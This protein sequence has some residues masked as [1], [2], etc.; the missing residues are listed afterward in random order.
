MRLPLSIAAM[1]ILA[2]ALAAQVL[3]YRLLD[4][5]LPPTAGY[6]DGAAD[7]D[8]DG[9]VD[10]LT[11]AG[12]LVGDGHANFAAAAGAP[13]AS[14]RRNTRVADLNGDGL[15]DVLSV[16]VSGVPR[17]DVNGGGLVFAQLPGAIPTLP[18]AGPLGL[19][20]VFWRFTTGDVD[21]DGD[22]DAVAQVKTFAI[23]NYQNGSPLVLLNNGSATFTVAP[24]TAFPATTVV[25]HQEDLAD[26]DG[27]GDLD[28]LLTGTPVAA[29]GYSR[30]FVLTNSGAGTFSPPVQVFSGSSQL[31]PGVG[32]FNGDGFADV[33]FSSSTGVAFATVMFGSAAGLGPGVN[34]AFP[35][36]AQRVIAIDLNGDGSDEVL[37]GTGWQG[38]AAVFSISAAG[39]VGAPTQTLQGIQLAP[40]TPGWDVLTDF[41]QDGDRDL[42]AIPMTTPGASM[43]GTTPA[44]L[45]NDGAGALVLLGG[46]LRNY[47]ISGLAQ[48]GD[49]DADGDL[50][51]LGWGAPGTVPTIETSLNDGDGFFTSGPL[52]PISAPAGTWNYLLFHA[53]DRDGDGDVD[54][55]AARNM[56][57]VNGTPG[58]DLVLDDVGGV[59][60]VAFTLA[61]TGPVTAI[62]DLDVDGDGDRDIVLGRRWPTTTTGPMTP[63]YLVSNL[64]AGGFAPAVPI[65]GGHYTYDLE[66]ADFD[67]NGSPDIFQTN[68]NFNP[69]GPVDPCELH[70]NAG[71]GAFAS[72]PQ[73]SM[74]GY[75]SAAGDVD[76]NGLPDVVLDSQVWLNNG[77][78]FTAGSA[79]TPA[80]G[81]PI[82]LADVDEDGDLDLVESPAGVRLNGG[83]GAFGPLLSQFPVAPYPP[84]SWTVPA[85]V[86][87]DFDRD[88]GPDVFG[89]DRRMHMNCSRQIALGMRARP[90]RPGSL[91]MW[92]SPGAIFAL[93]V[94]GAT[95]NFVYPPFGNVLIDPATAILLHGGTFGPT[96]SATPGFASIQGTIPPNPALVGLTL[97]WQMVDQSL[98]VSNRMK[99]TVAGY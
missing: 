87:A 24:T 80:V 5:P 86:V 95:A 98:R 10:L 84:T 64:G 18:V 90:G 29:G 21:G 85:S 97:Y 81:A 83:G 31:Y 11:S 93:F 96:G 6:P 1:L 76:G 68:R 34:S 60:S 32:D 91:E 41:D 78:T 82:S 92:G 56:L 25:T 77:G 61:D 7:F 43:S 14:V 28:V 48:V 20:A 70:L 26:L 73:P 45:M 47:S 19:P 4:E 55:Y 63:M 58:N 38:S 23:H 35:F 15:P 53:F 99:T 40:D 22:V 66:I 37:A 54:I 59:F 49:V 9:N 72:T 3:P 44:L 17:V 50:D 52:S 30:L 51:I 12:I 67:G 65:G 42:V 13:L 75:Y 74:T 57:S 39:V 16:S 36:W 46:R 27:D 33:A 94:S 62:R 2:P 8:Q 89:S 69:L 79:I 88:G 71:G